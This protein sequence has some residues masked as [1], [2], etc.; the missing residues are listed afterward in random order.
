M[1][2]I[3]GLAHILMIVASLIIGVGLFLIVKYCKPKVQNII[4][5]T[6]SGICVFG[7]FFLHA[8]KYFTTF[9]IKNLLIQMLQVCNFNFILIPLCLFKRNELAR[10]YLFFFSMPM[11]LSTFV[12]Y[13]SD[14]EGSMWYSVI[15]LTFWIN[16][17]LIALLPFLMIATKRFKPRL[18]YTWKVILCILAYFLI[19]FLGNYLLNGFQV[20]GPHNH[21]YT[22]GADGIML[23][24][25]LFKLIPIP[26][27]YLLPLLP[28]LYLLYWIAAKLF[29]KYNVPE[30]FGIGLNKKI[31]SK[32]IK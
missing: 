21:S 8:T 11:A 6:L 5:Y 31:K 20:I 24:I 28:I 13:P 19:A 26:F 12:S 25:P 27:V 10:Q 30:P 7:I 32:E 4:I 23:L 9:D 29:V 1:M 15:T 3:G 14:V 22:M 18:N 17:F 16:H 2:T